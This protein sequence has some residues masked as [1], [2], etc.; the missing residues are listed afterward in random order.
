MIQR[1]YSR[2]VAFRNLVEILLKVQ[3]FVHPLEAQPMEYKVTNSKILSQDDSTLIYSSVASD[4]AS[5]SCLKSPRDSRFVFSL[6]YVIV[7]AIVVLN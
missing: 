6:V 1:E 7:F 3:I 5:L 2:D 4:L